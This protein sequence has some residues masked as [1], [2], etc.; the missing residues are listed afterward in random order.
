LNVGVF[1]S[2]I[3]REGEAAYEEARQ[4]GRLVASRGGRVVCGGYGGVMEAACRGA[5]EEGGSSLGVILEGRPDANRWVTRV[6]PEPD[7]AARL[8]RLRDASDAWIFLPRGL[9]TMLEL[10]W[11]AESIVK[12]E[13]R[14]RPFVLLGDFWR[15][16]VE[17]AIEEAS[18]LPG[19]E[20][21]HACLAV[22]ASPA[23]AVEA[24]FALAK[25]GGS[26]AF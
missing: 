23:D 7:L 20:A 12:G 4:I 24:A 25:P 13:A 5:A 15:P 2:S 6:S 10:V 21:L 22:C 8:A 19:R 14:P 1:G 3:P 9:G 16:T 18:R 26:I 11:V 17:K